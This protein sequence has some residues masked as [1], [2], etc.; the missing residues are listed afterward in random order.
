MYCEN[1]PVGFVDPLGLFMTL[2]GTTEEKNL[3]YKNLKMLTRDDLGYNETDGGN[4]L[5]HYTAKSG[6]KY[7]AGT[8]LIRR[9]I[10]NAKGCIINITPYE[11]NKSVPIDYD[12]ASVKGIGSGGTIYYNPHVVFKNVLT[13]YKSKNGNIIIDYQEMPSE[14]IL[15]HELI[16]MLRAMNGNRIA[17]DKPN[18]NNL[19]G[20]Y[21][22]VNSDNQVKSTSEWMEELATT[23]ISYS[24]PDGSFADAANWVTTENAL[25]KEHGYGRRVKY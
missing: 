13:E 17:L 23:G 24:R 25:R 11:E 15:G 1:N 14:I 16:H 2:V 21:R 22:F 20:K 19:V 3:I 18:K 12:N 4:W 10:D 6:S 8:Q 7:N 5:V 9:I